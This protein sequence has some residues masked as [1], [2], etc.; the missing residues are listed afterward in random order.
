LHYPGDYGFIPQTLAEDDDPLDVL[1]MVNEPTFT[2]C[3]IETR[4][5]GLFKMKDHDANDF[6][7]FGVP[8]SDPLFSEFQ[9]LDDVP[10]H[11]LKEVE[12]FFDTYK[13]LEG[14]KT[15]T[16][17]WFSADDAIREVEESVKR[18]QQQHR[19]SATEHTEPLS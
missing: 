5:I 1:V 16:L 15:E 9:Q 2:G 11:Y 19:D 12:H 13:E 8:N 4:V 18:Y 17:G 7:V 6:K 10:S 3:L 14:V